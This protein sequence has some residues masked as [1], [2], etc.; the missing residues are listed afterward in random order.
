MSTCSSGETKKR[1]VVFT[2]NDAQGTVTLTFTA[3]G[4]RK[5]VAGLPVAN[6]SAGCTWKT[7]KKWKKGRSKVNAT[8]IPA[9]DSPYVGGNMVAT[10]KI[11]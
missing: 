10:V 7:P 2:V 6:G 9:A 4:K 1:T 11:S 8:C 3:S 5:V